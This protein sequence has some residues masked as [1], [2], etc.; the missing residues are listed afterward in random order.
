MKT[1]LFPQGNPYTPKNAPAQPSGRAAP[2]P[3]DKLAAKGKAELPKDYRV[4]L[5]AEAKTPTTVPSSTPSLDLPAP[6]APSLPS[7][8]PTPTFRSAA[9]GAVKEAAKEEVKDEALEQAKEAAKT[10]DKVKKGSVRKPALIFISGWQWMSS[11]SKSEGSYAGIGRMAEAIEGG[12]LYGWDQKKDILE[13][14]GRTHPE[15]PVV[16]VGHSL[17]GDTAVEVANELDSLEHGFRKVDFLVTLDAVGM[18]NDIIPQNVK[19]HLNVFGEGNILLNDGPHVG[20]R[21]EMTEVTNILSPL[22]HTE[23]DDAKDIQFEIV[24]S[25]NGIL[26]KNVG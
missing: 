14:I 18:N 11:P 10:D 25:I 21:H 13:Q 9:E 5:S 16:L 8:P 23:L 7:T 22:S 15:Q 20:R 19:K 4:D 24:A 3:G 17:G 6:A 2:V 12:R 1:D 26:G